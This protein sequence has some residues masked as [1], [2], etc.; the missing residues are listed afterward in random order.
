MAVPRVDAERIRDHVDRLGERYPP[1][2]LDSVDYS[3]RDPAAVRTRFARA[4]A[5]MARVELE[6]ERNVLELNVLLPGVSEIDRRFYADVW[7]PQEAQHGL[8]LDRLARRLKI[9]EPDPNLD[10]IPARVRVLG[11]LAHVP[12]IQDIIRLLYYLTGAATEKSAMLAYQAMSDGLGG[13]GELAIK[14]T[15]V[16]A[17]KVQE[18]G[19]FAFYRLSATH[20][21]QA[22]VLAPWQLHLARVLRSR[23][24][25]LVGAHTRRQRQDFGGVIV[26]LGMDEDLHSTIRDIVR[27]ENNLL[28]ARDHGLPVPAYAVAAFQDAISL[29]HAQA[30][31]H[32]TT[33]TGPDRVSTD[34]AVVRLGT[35]CQTSRV[36]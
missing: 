29:Y 2:D 31:D 18:P 14:N 16:D 15:V 33:G 6:V 23:S 3:V 28:W 7:S 13:M 4:L 30:T 12:A 8:V 24:F 26:N 17:I 32:E 21:L 27:V 34:H 1:I 10:R 5:Y 11:V 25:G 20:M 9:A 35:S 19:H 36:A 22:G